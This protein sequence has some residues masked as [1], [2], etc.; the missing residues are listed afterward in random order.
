M[1]TS[2]LLPQAPP[3]N[4]QPAP[5]LPAF[6]SHLTSDGAQPLTLISSVC[7]SPVPRPALSV[8]APVQAGGA[9]VLTD[10]DVL[11]DRNKAFETFRRSYRKSEAR[12]TSRVCVALRC[13]SAH[14]KRDTGARGGSA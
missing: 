3:S 13:I 10:L 4:T 2:M 8:R 9:D 7:P 14:K 1:R 6:T 11:A 5:A 12:L